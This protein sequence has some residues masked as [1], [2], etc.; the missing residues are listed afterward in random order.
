M[1]YRIKTARS[2]E[3]IQHLKACD[4]SFIPIL[5]QRVNIEEYGFKIADKAQTFEAWEGNVLAGLVAVYINVDSRTSFITNVSVI[6]SYS[7]IGLANKLL[8]NCIS[9]LQGI[10]I[11]KVSLEVGVENKAALKL[12]KKFNFIECGS[13]AQI[14]MLE[15]R[16]N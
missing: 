8:Q 2:V 12:Y 3:L 4:S 7:G 1:E 13:N 11:Q 5:S 15:L 6:K 16:L 10:K 14:K 9:F